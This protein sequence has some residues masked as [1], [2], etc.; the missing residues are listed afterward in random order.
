MVGRGLVKSLFPNF[1]RLLANT[2]QLIFSQKKREKLDEEK[3]AF[4]KH[5]ETKGK[6][7]TEKEK[8]FLSP[9]PSRSFTHAAHKTS[10]SA[11]NRLYKAKPQPTA[12][13]KRVLG[14]PSAW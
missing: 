11:N 1:L 14:L 5:K 3:A 13:Q 7:K 2:A 10:L 4:T 8:A 12:T 9:L 6:R